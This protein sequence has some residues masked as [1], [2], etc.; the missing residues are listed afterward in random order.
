MPVRPAAVPSLPVPLDAV[1]AQLARRGV[2]VSMKRLQEAAVAGAI[3]S[4]LGGG[5]RLVDEADLD[6]VE[7]YFRAYP[8]RPYRRGAGTAGRRVASGSRSEE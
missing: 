4:R 7:A 3:P 5:R 1:P 8:A 2:R 6:T